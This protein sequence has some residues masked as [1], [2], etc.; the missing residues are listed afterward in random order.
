MQLAGS[1]VNL[2]PQPSEGETPFEIYYNASRVRLIMSSF[3]NSAT[4]FAIQDVEICPNYLYCLDLERSCT[5]TCPQT[6]EMMTDKG[7]GMSMSEILVPSSTALTALVPSMSIA[8]SVQ[9]NSNTLVS[10]ARSTSAEMA[11]VATV[12]PL[13]FTTTDV[14]LPQ[15][16]MNINVP[17]TMTFISS[18][19]MITDTTV[20]ATLSL[21][22][23]TEPETTS[24]TNQPASL[25]VEWISSSFLAG[26]ML[27]SLVNPTSVNV[28]TTGVFDQPMTRLPQAPSTMTVALTS[29]LSSSTPIVSMTPDGLGDL[30]GSGDSLSLEPFPE[31]SKAPVVATATQLLATFT[32]PSSMA[33]TNTQTTMILTT[34]MTTTESLTVMTSTDSPTIMA[35]T[36][37]PTSKA[38]T[39]SADTSSSGSDGTII[40]IGTGLGLIAGILAI[41]VVVFIV[42]YAVKKHRKKG[43][44]R[45]HSNHTTPSRR[46]EGY[47]F[48]EEERV[49]CTLALK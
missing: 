43:V 33:T 40:G 18:S 20:G 17:L 47:F 29:E 16:T 1:D 38:P 7:S 10:I 13:N 37:E 24:V 45:P 8:S 32:F 34:T 35:S 28:M 30:I 49:V 23:V 39:V 41:I 48:E 21:Q 15:T 44:Y 5:T 14:M 25:A 26:D 46:D 4:N 11:E 31:T 6:A 19:I 9:E 36:E 42:V 27:S 12:V 3:M 2:R 22:P